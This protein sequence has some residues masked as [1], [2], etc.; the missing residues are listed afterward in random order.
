M[1]GRELFHLVVPADWNAALETGQ[2]EPP[3]LA[4]EGFIH[5]SFAHQVE[6]SANR[7]YPDAPRLLA[8]RVDA[9]ELVVVEEDTSG[10][11]AFPHLYGF[12]PTKMVIEVVEL[13]RV[14]GRWRMP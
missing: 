11:G 6:R 3:S 12:L 4:E 2:Y 7:F 14:E 5:L 13:E 10:H 8:L 1:S 9:R